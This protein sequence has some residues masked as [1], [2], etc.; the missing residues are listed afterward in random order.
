MKREPLPR[1]DVSVS[2]SPESGVDV[3][4]SRDG[5]A[6]SYKGDGA[7]REQVIKD[8]VEKIIGDRHTGEWLPLIGRVAFV[9]ALAVLLA[10]CATGCIE[11]TPDGRGLTVCGG[12]S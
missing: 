1:P 8:V 5:K 2:T 9:L 3:V 7:I 10:G 4:I 11:R 12:L 6:K